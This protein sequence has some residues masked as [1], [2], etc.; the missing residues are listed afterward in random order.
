MVLMPDTHVDT[1]K[2]VVQARSRT[3]KLQVEEECHVPAADDD[4]AA[5]HQV[6]QTPSSAKQAAQAR[7]AYCTVVA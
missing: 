4:D 1:R 7:E 6:C 3:T 2:E 5:Q